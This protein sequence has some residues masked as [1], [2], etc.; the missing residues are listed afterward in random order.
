LQQLKIAIVFCFFN[1]L[2]FLGPNF[3]FPVVSMSRG[4]L[5]NRDIIKPIIREAE[6]KQIFSE[7]G[8]LEWW[9]FLQKK[10]QN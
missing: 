7:T 3:Q 9:N 8:D 5:T 2:Y 6:L 10:N 4:L 1:I